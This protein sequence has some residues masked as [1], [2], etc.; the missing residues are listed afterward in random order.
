MAVQK[1]KMTSIIGRMNEL[2]E[3]T[4]RCGKTE[5]FHPDNV[6][7][8]HS[9]TESFVPIADD[10]PY[11]GTLHSLNEACE[12]I[13]K[14]L[15][16]TEEKKANE[17][18]SDRS[19]YEYVSQFSAHVDEYV[20]RR[21]EVRL[22]V[23]ELTTMIYDVS[24]FKGMGLQIDTVYNR[25]YVKTRF[26]TLSK[27]SYEKL[28]LL[29][30]DHPYV[31]FF[32]FTNDD[33][34]YWGA[35]FAPLDQI[36]EVDRIFSGLYFKH[37]D[38]SAYHGTPE[39]ALA[40]LE[41]KKQAAVQKIQ[42]LDDDMN[43]FWEKEQHDCQ[44]V[45]NT[46][47]EKNVYFNI[48]RYGARYHESFILTGWVPATEETE[49]KEQLESLETVE[50][51]FENAETQMEHSPPIQLKNPKPFRP[52]EFFVE[53]FGLPAYNEV[54]PTIFVGITYMLLFGIMFGDV[55]QGLVVSLVGWFMWNKMHMKLGRILIPCGISSAFFGMI[56]GSVFGF[57]HLLDP[58]YSSVFGLQEKP[59]HVMDP[60]TIGMVIAAAV[61]IGL[62]LVVMA[63]LINIYSCIKKKKYGH[64]LF[65]SSGFAGLVFYCAVVF[66][67]GGKIVAGWDIISPAYVIALIVL[68]LILIFFREILAE[69]VE[70][71]KHWQ[72]ESWGDFIMQNF[73]EMIEVLLSYA[74]NTMSFL[75]VGAFVLVHA[76]MMMVV[77]TL[78]EMFTG[79]G[80]VM[81]VA[82]G[83]VFVMALEGLLV[84]IQVLRLEFYEMFSR[85][86]EGTGRPFRPV[87]VRQELN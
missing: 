13:K 22:Q 27:E 36:A 73:F 51:V 15:S 85:F 24:H 14:N 79:V 34:L 72:P 77:F 12:K 6:L 37:V 31:M 3:V 26:G 75:R 83:N 68:P 56:Y 28:G 33:T 35:Y 54:D 45:F 46:L 25:T 9:D 71:H 84:G 70:G 58:F 80:Y 65:D 53:M 62:F 87:S 44:R 67:F 41:S 10:N 81:I 69:I 48:R 23:N 19:L 49:F 86:F 55:G 2:E 63:M 76:G 32:P 43:A 42:Q 11:A 74:T 17:V 16:F 61:G 52:F 57:E 60:T 7:S 40:E 78:A 20:K 18:L 1:I 38:L 8:F 21:E 82:I 66:G 29:Y 50:Y 64:A 30:G 59:V 39:E 4:V 47:T 5:A